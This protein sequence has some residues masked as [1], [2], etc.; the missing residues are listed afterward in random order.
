M[1]GQVLKVDRVMDTV[2]S[3]QRFHVTSQQIQYATDE[4]LTNTAPVDIDGWVSP[5]S[6]EGATLLVKNK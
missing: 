4:S 1:P 5:V 2:S 6:R 3:V